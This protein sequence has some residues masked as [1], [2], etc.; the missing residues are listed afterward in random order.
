LN[1][2]TDTPQVA[3]NSSF[4]P[5]RSP[6]SDSIAIAANCSAAWS[7]R[8]CPRLDLRSQ[9]LRR[10]AGG[11]AVITPHL[12]IRNGFHQVGQPSQIHHIRLARIY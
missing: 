7:G 12:P 5:S 4:V 1:V 3:R 6:G 9:S 2:P 11:S 10:N 8:D